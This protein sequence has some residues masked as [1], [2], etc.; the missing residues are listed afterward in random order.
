MYLFIFILVILF[1]YISSVNPS[2]NP[3]FHLP[4]PCFYKGAPPPIHQLPSGLSGSVD[5][6]MII[7]YFT[8]NVHL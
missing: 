5:G 6:S 8:V 7:L 2:L 4:F 3:L 1:I